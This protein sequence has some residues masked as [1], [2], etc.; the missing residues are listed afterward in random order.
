MKNEKS[1]RLKIIVTLV[2]IMSVFTVSM[3]RAQPHKKESR[4]KVKAYMESKVLPVLRTRRQKLEAELTN[5][6]KQ[7]ISALREQMHTLRKAGKE[8]R[9]GSRNTR[10]EERT[11][12]EKAAMSAERKKRKQLMSEVMA[13]ADQHEATIEKL[14]A[15]IE[16][17]Q[18]QW[19]ADIRAIMEA[20]GTERAQGDTP[21]RQ[22]RGRRQHAMQINDPASF[23]LLNPNAKTLEEIEG[24]HSS[25]YPNPV[26]GESV[27]EYQLEEKGPVIITVFDDKGIPVKSLVYEIQDKGP[28]KVSMEANELKAGTYL[29]LLS[30]ARGTET[31]RFVKL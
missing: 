27:L 18:Q 13:I 19:K 6:E 14:L 11:E 7:Q 25:L 15:G 30:T 21:G 9:V 23:L 24:S 3:V 31:S 5:Q 22:G 28:Y 4:E 26:N 1:L 16:E 29:Y 17:Q 10:G 2:V 8:K 12:A 20:S